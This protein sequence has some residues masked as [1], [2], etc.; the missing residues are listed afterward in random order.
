MR[1]SIS[2]QTIDRLLIASGIIGLA[3]WQIGQFVICVGAIMAFIV[4]IA[5]LMT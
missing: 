4:A 3:I 5:V 1:I 2:H